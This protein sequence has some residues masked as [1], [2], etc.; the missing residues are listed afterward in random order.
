MASTITVTKTKIRS[1]DFSDAVNPTTRWNNLM[2]NV[3]Y[4]G[5]IPP[6]STSLSSTITACVAYVEGVR[7][8]TSAT[9]K[10]FTANKDTYVDLD[11]DGTL[12]YS[13]VANG[14]AEP[15]WADNSLRLCKVVTGAAAVTSVV[16]LR[17]NN[18]GFGMGAPVGV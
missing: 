1:T 16:D 7:V 11:T 18:A 8:S 13:E 14:A 3:V 6:T 2:P 9:A 15:T 10:T 4:S 17:A 5:G 12:Q